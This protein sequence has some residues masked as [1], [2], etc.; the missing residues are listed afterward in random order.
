MATESAIKYNILADTEEKQL[1]LKLSASI[2]KALPSDLPIQE[3]KAPAS[4]QKD[5][6]ITITLRSG[7][8][9]SWLPCQGDES[10]QRHYHV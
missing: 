3:K 8:K 4:L 2:T 6:N 7:A 1:G 10:I 5:W 9:H